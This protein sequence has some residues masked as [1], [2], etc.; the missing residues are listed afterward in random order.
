MSVSGNG[1]HSMENGRPIL[2]GRTPAWG[3]FRMPIA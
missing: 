1:R 3:S 2:T